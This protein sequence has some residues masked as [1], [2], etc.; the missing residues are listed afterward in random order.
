MHTS[1]F[2]KMDNDERQKLIEW[3]EGCNTTR[4]K[5]IQ[6]MSKN[7]VK[8]V[9]KTWD[10]F[11][12]IGK[13]LREDWEFELP[14]DDSHSWVQVLVVTSMADDL[15]GRGWANF[16]VQN[17]KNAWLKVLKGGHLA[18]LTHMDDIFT[19]FLI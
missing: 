6:E 14:L 9:G 15:M 1:L 2:D 4:H 7:A 17:F 3:C 5:L 8:S 19:E 13:V 12:S 18:L 16:I 10:G 11:L